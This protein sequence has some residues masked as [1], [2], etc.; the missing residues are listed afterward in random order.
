MAGE[1]EERK[2]G[3]PEWVLWLVIRL[4]QGLCTTD[5]NRSRGI[6]LPIPRLSVLHCYRGPV[7]LL[8]LNLLE[9]DSPSWR[10]LTRLGPIG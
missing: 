3:Q 8:L 1:A 10:Q 5:N 4:L 6:A 9:I 7:L 2:S